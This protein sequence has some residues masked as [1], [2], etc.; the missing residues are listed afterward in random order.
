MQFK[1]NNLEKKIWSLFILYISVFHWGMGRQA[2]FPRLLGSFQSFILHCYMNQRPFDGILL[3]YYPVLFSCFRYS[4][5]IFFV[6]WP[7]PPV[8]SV[9]RTSLK[10]ETKKYVYVRLAAK[11]YKSKIYK[12]GLSLDMNYSATNY[13]YQTIVQPFFKIPFHH[14]KPP[15]R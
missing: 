5:I 3:L 4:L 12:F 13:D 2:L 6:F 15:P 8:L 7:P 9:V 11:N 1:F 10:T 14:S